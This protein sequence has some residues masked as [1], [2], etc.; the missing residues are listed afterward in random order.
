MKVE[1]TVYTHYNEDDENFVIKYSK[2][3]SND[4]ISSLKLKNSSYAKKNI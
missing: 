4:E 1:Y 2:I 3:G